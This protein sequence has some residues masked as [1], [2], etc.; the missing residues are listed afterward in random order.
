MERLRLPIPNGETPLTDPRSLG[1]SAVFHV[2]L[3]VLGMLVALKVAAPSVPSPP[4][5]LHAEVGP[6]DNR[7]PAETGGGGPGAIGGTAPLESARIVADGRSPEG[8]TKDPA[9]EALL[10]DVFSTPKADP[11]AEKALPGPATTGVGIL[12]GPGDG[13]GGGS[14]GGSGGGI[15][16]G[17]G[18]G[19]EFFGARARGGSFAYVIDCSGSMTNRGALLLAKRELLASLD[20]LPPDA[21][22]AVVFYNMKANVLT[23]AEGRRS[24]MPAT[25]E[26]KARVR[27]LLSTIRSDGGTDHVLAL[28]EAFALKPEVVF[29]LTDAERMA[30]EDVDRLRSDSGSIQIQAIQFGD[31]PD[32]G[33]SGPLR[34]LAISTGGGFQYVDLSE[35]AKKL[36]R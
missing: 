16:R 12:P 18:P 31:G 6:V 17:V 33:A 29:F 30:D 27:T 26:N 36:G 1:T 35:V 14:G 10:A 22:F 7:A 34:R 24:L 11:A 25:R 3:I 28:H 5:V 13:G 9:A 21:R 15:G 2:A 32:L 20:Q 4:E 19:T 8:T 23:D